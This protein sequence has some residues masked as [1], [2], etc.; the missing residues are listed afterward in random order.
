MK[1]VAERLSE[2]DKSTAP[3]LCRHLAVY[4]YT[5]QF[6]KD[7]TVLDLGCGEGYGTALLARYA[8]KVIGV[9]YSARTIKKAQETYACD[10]LEF[11][12]GSIDQIKLESES[13]EVISAFQLIEH[14]PKPEVFLWRVKNWLKSEGLFFLSTPNKKSSIIQHPYHFR[15]YYKEELEPLL[16]I[17]F[18]K[19]ELFGL[20]FSPKVA[21]FREKRKRESQRVL[22][23]DPLKL[24]LLLPRFIRQKIFDL[25]AAK[26]SRKIHLENQDLIE[27]ITTGD[28]WISREDID[29]AVDLVCI[30]KNQPTATSA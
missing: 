28:Y 3:I 6:V 2:A 8:K 4:E 9:D 26:L 27:G 24:H 1:T 5:Q 21:A 29:L 11:V 14:L 25:I 7:K 23:V 20:R 17:Y 13:F 15:E 18:S 22:Q 16:K 10:N 12:C 19:V 30:S